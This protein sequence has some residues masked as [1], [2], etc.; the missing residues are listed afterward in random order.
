MK[1]ILPAT[2]TWFTS[3]E[4]MM[5]RTIPEELFPN[6]LP[7]VMLLNDLREWYGKPIYIHSTYRS[8]EYNQ[9]V[10][11]KKNSL[12]LKFNAID[13]GVKDYKDLKKLY[14][15]LNEWDYNQEIYHWPAM[16]LGLYERQKFIHADTRGKFG[17]RRARW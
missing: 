14:D 9:A 1:L 6:I 11:G 8:P 15:K 13:F 3:E 17:M 16:G 12:H 5:G 7:T 10:G 4:I 2:V